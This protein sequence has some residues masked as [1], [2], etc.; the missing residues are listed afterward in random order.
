MISSPGFWNQTPIKTQPAIASLYDYV[1][2]RSEKRFP[3]WKFRFAPDLVVQLQPRCSKSAYL[4]EGLALQCEGAN[5]KLL[6]AKL[7]DIDR[8]Y[9]RISFRVTAASPKEW[10][11]KPHYCNWS[12]SMARSLRQEVLLK[13][14]SR[15]VNAL[16]DGRLDFI[17]PALMLSP[18]CLFCGKALTDPVSMARLIGPECAGTSSAALPFVI[19]LKGAA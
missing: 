4:F 6:T 10:V 11:F 2:E 18:H 5:A 9:C 19:E 14:R 13:L 1:L 3:K 17:T 16:E 12:P 15:I 7:C 8:D